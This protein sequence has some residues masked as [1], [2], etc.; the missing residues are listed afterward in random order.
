MSQSAT[1]YRV[2]E[3]T[4][5]Q[6]EQLGNKRRL[7][8]DSTKSYTTFQGSF[9]GLEFI[10][11][12]G[13]DPLA[14][15]LINQIFNPKQSLGEQEFGNLTPEEQFEYYESGSLIPYLERDTISKLDDFL[16]EVSDAY[17]HLN[18]DAQE[19]N[20]NGIYPEVWH[21]DNSPNQGYNERELLENLTELK[22]IIREAKQEKDY[23]LVFV[24]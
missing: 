9:M 2:S 13:Q 17:I 8:T 6:L 10:L 7:N 14:A 22:N 3:D 18:Y 24:G 1:L 12:K 4:F 11:S 5:K 16:T 15:E 21:N 19:F 23:I 20:D